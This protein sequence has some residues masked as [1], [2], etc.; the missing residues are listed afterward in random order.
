M[1]VYVFV[2]GIQGTSRPTKYA[3]L[4]DENNFTADELYAFTYNTCY[5]YRLPRT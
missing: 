5:T 3:V 4:L 2:L 1:H